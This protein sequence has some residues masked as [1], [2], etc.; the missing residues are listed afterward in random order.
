MEGGLIL[1]PK[2]TEHYLNFIRESGYDSLTDLMKLKDANEQLKEGN[3][4]LL[5]DIKELE[6][7]S[8]K[9]SSDMNQIH[10]DLF[11]TIK[12]II[13][14]IKKLPFHKYNILF[15]DEDDLSKFLKFREALETN[16][17]SFFFLGFKI[18]EAIEWIHWISR[19]TISF[20][21]KDKKPWY[22]KIF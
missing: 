13:K 3:S 17:F 19:L 12:T 11:S 14:E 8:N 22:K 1:S 2:E 4:V 16:E 10:E 5:K 15:K 20:E 18:E 21:E 6:S 9:L 7:K